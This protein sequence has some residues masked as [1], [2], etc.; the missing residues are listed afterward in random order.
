MSKFVVVV[1]PDEAKAYQATR[2]LKELHAEGGLTLYG[3]AVITKDAN[4]RFAVK[5]AADVGPLGTAVGAL[6]GGLVGVV[7]GPVV[8]LA[9]VTGGALIGGLMDMFNYGV[10]EDF[11][12]K[13]SNELGRGKTAVV[14]EIV[15]DWTTP[16]DTRMEALGGMVLRTWR[17]DFEDEQIANEVSARQ[18]DFEQLRIEYAQANAEAKAKLKAKVDNAKQDLEDAEKRLQAKIDALD[19]ELEAKI[20]ALEK[21]IA[22]AQ[23]EAKEKLKKRIASLRAEYEARSA[24]LKQAWALTKEALAA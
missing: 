23:A 8:A 16:L 6:V 18:V 11:V 15:E 5:E 24:K 9:G 12:G 1:F 13:V 19:A 20:A 7:G 21:Q 14:A 3:T 17:A 22:D 10:S 2:A 4:G